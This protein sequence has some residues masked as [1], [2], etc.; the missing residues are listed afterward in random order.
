MSRRDRRA[1][2]AAGK[3]TAAP[4]SADIP[5]LIA[6]AT[7]AYRE[8]RAL[9]AEVA[10]KRVLARL[11]AHAEA[12]NILGVVHQAHG[13]HRRAVRSLAEAIA[14]NDL[15]AASHYNIAVSY[16]ALG[17]TAAAIRHYKKAIAL[18]LSGQGVEP[19]LLQDAVI[20]RCANIMAGEFEALIKKDDPLESRD[21]AAL[22]DNLFL[23][24]ALE[25]TIIRG[26][27]LELFLT[28]LRRALLR[29]AVSVDGARTKGDDN[30]VLLLGAVA[31]QCFL[32]EYVVAQTA[33]ETQRAGRFRELLL[34]GLSS[35]AGQSALLIAVTAAYF[36]LHSLPGAEK[37]LASEP[38]KHL[39]EL[40]RVQVREPLQEIEDRAAIPALTPVKNDTSIAVMQQYEQNPYPRWT[41]NAL[42]AVASPP[43]P[44]GGQGAAENIL[45]AGCGTGEHPV[46]IAQRSPAAHILA[47]DLSLPSLAYARRKTRELGLHN[48]EYAQADILN[49]SSLGRSFDRIEV[50]GVLHH[51]ADPL[52]GWRVLLSLLAPGGI[53][54]IGLYSE[55]AR[56][57]IVEART[58]VGQR[59]FQPTPD[60][61]RALRQA[62]IRDR[63][64]S[65]W[66]PLVKTVDFYSVSGCRDMF[67]NVM[68]HRFTIAQ[69]KSFLS[70]E[71]LEFLGFDVAPALAEKFQERNPAADA[72]RDLDCWAV[73]EADNPQTFRNMYIFSVQRKS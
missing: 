54:H 33:E 1:A 69:I 41:L 46:E 42:A 13:N 73:F 29:H 40:L 17:E 30:I 56:A 55:L 31:Q 49:L 3:G 25:T 28:G 45:I 65:R 66:Q 35:G 7:L 48:I 68:E 9:D 34:Q 37:L 44:G 39:A 6:E 20:A 27:T 14:V 64:E 53:M 70:E 67:F 36:P 23:R 50:L 18:G 8:G 52:A 12:L 19:F 51:L 59:G 71:D 4:V 11:P 2:L 58:L 32:N 60:G 21:L 43:V 47:V 16:Q 22:A 10:C 26:I 5:A 72:L 61:I 57:S 24:C 63:N 15:D 62:I 38:P